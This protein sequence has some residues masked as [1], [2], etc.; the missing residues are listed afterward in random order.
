MHYLSRVLEPK[1]KE[2]L[3]NFSVLGL[4]G[5]RQ[6][7]KST[8]LTHTLKEYKYVTFDDPNIIH[9]FSTDPN[10]FMRI[11]SNKIIFDEVQKVPE[12]FNYI[13]IA[14]DNDRQ[15]MVNLY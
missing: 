7:G 8:L 6:S 13:K 11:Y 9:L 15:I 1:L 14:V 10:K 2:Y 12:I 5:P 3:A 4:T